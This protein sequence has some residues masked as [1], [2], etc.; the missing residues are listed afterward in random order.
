MGDQ[1]IYHN[2]QHLNHSMCIYLCH[3]R[4]FR[5]YI[6]YSNKKDWEQR[7]REVDMDV[8]PAAAVVPL[9]GRA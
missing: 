7:E 4:G 8:L 5:M 1:P 2:K 3:T 6:V 9:G